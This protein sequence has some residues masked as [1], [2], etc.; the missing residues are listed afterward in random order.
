M[1]TLPADIIY[2]ILS[3]A[4]Y[5]EIDN[6]LPCFQLNPNKAALIKQKIYNSRLTIIH[7]EDDR[8]VYCIEDYLHREDGPAIEYLSDVEY[9]KRSKEW[10]I[11]GELHRD[12]DLPAIEY[13]DGTKEW[14]YRDQRHRDN[15]LPAIEHADG[16][17]TWC[18][19]GKIHRMNGPAIIRADGSKEWYING[20]RLSLFYLF[21]LY[22]K[23]TICNILN[24]FK[25]LNL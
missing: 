22:I 13:T 1:D 15:D 8:I 24:F 25:K 6:I 9:L 23:D 5:Y 17:K 7:E 4:S 11:N 21:V 20:K 12:N 3:F 16:G 19:H 18:Y 14:Y 10:C 2:N